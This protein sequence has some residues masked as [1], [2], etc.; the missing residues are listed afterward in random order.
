MGY[1]QQGYLQD[2]RLHRDVTI[3]N[4]TWQFS[5]SEA[6]VLHNIK[7]LPRESLEGRSPCHKLRLHNLDFLGVNQ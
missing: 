6:A 5:G 7:P 3:E 4:P 1:M 2:S